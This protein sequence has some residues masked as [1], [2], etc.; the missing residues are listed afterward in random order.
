VTF[1]HT[2][3]AGNASTV[4]IVSGNGQDAA[5]GSVLPD[6]LV[7]RVLDENGNPIVD[8]P[9]S[10]VV[11]AGGG[12]ANP[13]TSNTNGEGLATS[14][15]TLGPTPGNNTLNAVVSG[16]G[17][18]PF[19]ATATGVGSPSNLAVITQP[20]A[21]IT[22]GATLSPGP[23]VQIR[24]NAGHDLAV[25]GVEVT[26]SV[27]SGRGQLEGTRTVAT[28]ANGRAAFNDLRIT[29][30][31][32]S[33]KL[34]FAADGYRSATSN[35]IEVEKA[36]TTTAVTDDPDPTNPGEAV[37]VSVTVSSPAGTPTGEVEI[38]ANGSPSCTVAAPQGSCQV[39]PTSS[40]DITATYKGSDVFGSSS[41]TTPHQVNPPVNNPPVAA[42]NHA[43]CVAGT[44]CQF[45]DVSTDPEGNSTIVAWTW[46][47]GDFTDVSHD[48]NPTHNYLV[49]AGFS[50]Q[51]T[52]TV[53]DNQGA[54]NS[55]V[56]A[57]PVQ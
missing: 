22:V 57:V 41:A 13:A 8:R 45:T 52:L 51:V 25:P 55:T 12:T 38:S 6:P 7:V 27:S 26:V 39:T 11:G 29:G 33:H 18:A 35:K 4:T 36:S 19:T 48:Q 1:T 49:G 50:Y 16:V 15:W 10:W 32:G 3:T 40:G 14:R 28:D 5:A 30:A 44:A 24:D 17:T 54:T 34:I 47:F 9:V 23:V 21:S 20:P 46:D 37:T 43:D 42:F 53:T 31:S 2:A 56:Q